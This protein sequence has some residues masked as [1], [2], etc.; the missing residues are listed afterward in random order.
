MSGINFK[1]L[2]NN[3][4]YVIKENQIKIGYTANPVGLNYPLDSLNRL[5]GT[6]C[7]A[8]EMKNIINTFSDFVSDELGEIKSEQNGDKFYITVPSEGVAYIHENIEDS[9]FLKEFIDLFRGLEPPKIEEIFRVFK[10]YGDTA[11]CVKVSDNEFNYVV[12]FTDGEPDEFI[13]CIDIDDDHVT[14]HRFTHD[15]FNALGFGEYL[16]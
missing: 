12:Y 3:I 15:D 9:E 4:I 2:K 11:R 7:D 13:Y 16:K 6:N 8:D 14:Y 10:K 1:A 5:L